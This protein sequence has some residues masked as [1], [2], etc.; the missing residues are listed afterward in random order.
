M[1]Y[2][3]IE[4]PTFSDMIYCG[5]VNAIVCILF[6]CNATA[7]ARFC[8]FVLPRPLHCLGMLPAR[9]HACRACRQP[10]RGVAFGSERAWGHEV[11]VL[12]DRGKRQPTWLSICKKSVGHERFGLHIL[13][14]RRVCSFRISALSTIL[15]NWL[16]QLLFHYNKSYAHIWRARNEVGRHHASRH[17]LR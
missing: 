3:N 10:V 14:I 17:L 16:F 12:A 5:R 6:L 4:A 2:Q 8:D 7:A 1:H 11:Q 13:T 9:L 15:R